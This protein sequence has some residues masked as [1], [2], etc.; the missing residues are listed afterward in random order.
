LYFLALATDYD[1]TIAE[2]GVVSAETCAALQA[3]KQTGRR[4][5]MVTGRELP[6][7]K[8][9]FGELQLFDL[10]VAE[11]GALLYNPASEEERVIAPPPSEKFIA[12]LEAK[13]VAPLSVGR[14]IVATW[15]PHQNEVLE[16]I[17]ELGL[18]L[19]IIFNKGAVMVLPAG[20]NKATGLAAALEELQLSAHNVVGVGDAEN[21]HAFMRACGCSAAVANALPMVKDTADIRLPAP[22][23]AGVVQLIDMIARKDA[24]IVPPARH[25]ISIGTD[26]AG[27][28]VYIEPYRGSVLIAGSSGIGKS[29]LAAALT[30]RMAERKFEFCVFDPEGDYDTLE[31]AVPVGDATTVPQL[32]EIEKLLSK[33]VNVTVN[34]QAL[35]V[36]E[37]PPFFAKLLPMIASR[38]AKTGRPHWL[39]IDEAHHLL[40]AARG[41]IAAYLP[42]EIPAGIF[43]TVHPEAVAREA[44][45]TVDRVIALGE[46]A[47]SV[48]GAYCNAI[49][50]PVPDVPVPA[51]RDEFLIWTSDGD[52]PPYPVKAKLPRQQRKRHTRKY[53]D[54][55]LGVDRSFYFRGTDGA[56]NLRAQN[57]T[58]FLQMAEG[59]DDRTWTHHLQAGDYSRWFRDMIK[60]DDLAQEARVVESDESLDPK[61]SRQRIRE[62]VTRRYTAPASSAAD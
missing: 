8:R 36:E 27:E 49:G 24:R 11:N 62:A 41:D 28:E 34:T 57:L 19:Q 51:T 54:G 29:T 44:L 4:L 21:D 39:L 1:G 10:V 37:R 22:R 56:L 2:E 14:S 32:S 25:G 31:N 30:E 12:R 47:P 3:F 53:A 13:N 61:Q 42:K 16:A 15:E 58:V 17:H 35:E 9:V 52:L 45:K 23:G 5:I 40:P 20:V 33:G 59:V 7:L 18:E 60:D 50:L 38:R 6:D 43:I 48:I 46:K 55:D 26:R